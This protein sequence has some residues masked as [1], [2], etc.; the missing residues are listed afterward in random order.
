M[1]SQIINTVDLN[2]YATGRESQAVIPE[3][4][5]LLVRQS[6]SNPSTCRIPYGEAINKP[7]WDG[8]VETDKGFREFV[9]DGRSYWEIGTGNNP[10]AKFAE[11]FN[12][13]TKQVAETDKANASIIL[14]TPRSFPK[15]TEW[16][17]KRKDKGW[18][19]IKIIDDVKLADWLRGFPAL[20]RWMAKK[21]GISKN[22]GGFFT[23]AEH[24]EIIQSP[25]KEDDDPPIPPEVFTVGRE[26]A[27]SALQKL[28][29]GV[30]NKLPFFAE[31]RKDVK[32][33]VSAYLASLDN[34]KRRYF[35][36][37]CLFIEDKETW[38]SISEIVKSH[39]LVA[40]PKLGLDS[41]NMDFQT[42]ATNK[43]HSVIIPIFGGLSVENQKIVR[44]RSPDK[45]SIKQILLNKNFSELRA[46][47]MAAIGAHSLSAL[48]RYMAGLGTA[49]PYANRDN[50]RFLAEAGL[51]GQWDGN[52]PDDIAA[53]EHLL[54]KS[55]GEWIGIVR[56]ETLRSDAPLIQYNEKWRIIPRQEAWD[57][58]GAQLFDKDLERFKE[59]ALKVLG[60][61]DP[62]FDLPKKERYMAV[63][64]GKTLSYSSIIR[65]GI[66]ETLALI[67]SRPK[68]LSSCSDEKANTTANLIVRNILNNADWERWQ[69]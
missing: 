14:V 58:L 27:C 5:Y 18:R 11:D 57:Y 32:D 16:I 6:I 31:S 67:G 17:D 15:Q 65:G 28:L 12:K 42:I 46:E 50:A 37:K 30:S 35:S 13:R 49:P 64:H 34:E 38:L 59:T 10:K 29:E 33:F 25:K 63:I 45:H 4:I 62:Q 43:G 22:I 40:N 26:D 24:W 1:Y 20:V 68:A 44:L 8:I 66:A 47:K 53:L 3:L 69:A 54:G 52:N 23:P 21:I 36:N 60:E 48:R 41:E 39:I 19:E 61:Y 55:Y 56:A 2:H 51:I 9:P 7:E